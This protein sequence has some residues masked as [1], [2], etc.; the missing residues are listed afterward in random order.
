MRNVLAL[1]VGG[2]CAPLV[3]AIRSYEPIFVCFFATGGSKGSR[4]TVDGEGSPCRQRTDE[5]EKREHSIVAQTGLSDDQYRIVE[6]AD[7][8]D[9]P[10]I[11]TQCMQMLRSLQDQYPNARYI[12]DYT[13]GSKSM[14]VGLVLAALECG[15]ELSL[16][17]GQRP[18]LIKVANGTEM[19]GL[20]GSG[21]VRARRRL[22]EARR[23][24]NS[25]AYASA[26]RLLEESLRQAPLS[27]EIE[28]S[29]RKM[30][31]LC[32]G[33]D[34][35]DRFDHERAYK[36]LRTVQSE[37][38]PQWRFL[39]RLLGRDRA[40]GY[41]PVMDLIRN[42]ERCATRGRYD[43]AVARLYRA[44]EMMAQIR[45][46]HQY[47]VDTGNVQIEHLPPPLQTR[48][49]EGDRLGLWDAYHL[50]TELED[51]LGDAFQQH[52]DRLRDALQQR[53]ASI[54]AHGTHP[55]G[56]KEYQ[57][58]YAIVT[59]FV[60]AGMAAIGIEVEAPQFPEREPEG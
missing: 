34:A 14:G 23:L 29:I 4:I 28:Q 22:E 49:K 11:F 2:S 30:V 19:A 55:V 20:I 41:E 26:E 37:I 5:G 58:I 39:K 17:R 42:A 33:F 47:Q 60:E 8:D 24:F 21:E 7:P 57:R 54:L 3:C 46:G 59:A 45:L 1:T 13:G 31:V 16:V 56:E 9:L 43:D 40:S 36:I 6:L 50:L 35:W 51:P 44:V 15:W 32:R 52:R 27:R 53:N 18:D 10:A 38:V 48:Y 25:Y 12:A